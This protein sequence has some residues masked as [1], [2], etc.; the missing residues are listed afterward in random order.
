MSDLFKKPWA[1]PSEL[2]KKTAERI[3]ILEEFT[4]TKAK[5]TE[6]PPRESPKANADREGRFLGLRWMEFHPNKDMPRGWC[7]LK[8]RWVRGWSL[9]Y[10]PPPITS[11]R[12]YVEI[13]DGGVYSGL[14]FDS[15]VCKFYSVKQNPTSFWQRMLPKG[16]YWTL[17]RFGGK[18]R[19]SRS[20][21]PFM[22]WSLASA[23]PAKRIMNDDGTEDF[24][25]IT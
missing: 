20:Q 10:N 1:A 18:W 19:F 14:Y 7:L 16:M 21:T 4:R 2:P 15:Q 6:H 25:E 24:E 11:R 12:E 23:P 3:S 8:H 13:T 5:Y 9:S 22:D 17:A